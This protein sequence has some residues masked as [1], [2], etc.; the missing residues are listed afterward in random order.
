[1]NH[2]Y[3]CDTTILADVTAYKF[4]KRKVVIRAQTYFCKKI[5]ASCEEEA[6]KKFQDTLKDLESNID[7]EIDMK[8]SCQIVYK[9]ITKDLIYDL[10]HNNFVNEC[11]PMYIENVRI[12]EMRAIELTHKEAC[13]YF[14][15]EDIFGEE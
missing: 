2:F 4:F 13:K 6:L 9:P 11:K 8:K 5:K 10:C 12:T 15:T 7:H 3:N 14:T 1:M